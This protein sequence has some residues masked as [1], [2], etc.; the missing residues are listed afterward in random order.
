MN[1]WTTLDIRIP[2][3]IL[4]ASLVG[5]TRGPAMAPVAGTIL[6]DG[7]PLST[8]IITVYQK[9]YR[10]ATATIQSDGR[11]EFKTLTDGDGCLLGEHPITV[12]ST[13]SIS[14]T[15][16]RCFIPDRYNDIRQSDAKIKIDGPQDSLIINLTWK[17]SGHHQPYVVTTGSGDEGP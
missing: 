14:A 7:T 1:F 9:G 15:A 6:I 5:C 10:P 3:I 16:T 17:G 11:F 12:M 4:V 2:A 13:Q 8:G